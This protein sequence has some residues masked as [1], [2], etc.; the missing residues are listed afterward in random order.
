[1]TS[2]VNWMWENTPVNWAIIWIKASLTCGN[3]N[4]S[5]R[6]R[7]P[8]HS[9]Q[10]PTTKKNL[11]RCKTG[12]HKEYFASHIVSR[13][14]CARSRCR[15][16]QSMHMCACAHACALFTLQY[17]NGN[18]Q[19]INSLVLDKN[20]SCGSR[21][22]ASLL[23]GDPWLWGPD[24]GSH[25]PI[26]P[27]PEW[28]RQDAPDQVVHAVRWWWEAAVNRGGACP[29]H[30]QGCQVHIY[31]RYAGLY[32]R[33]CVDVNDN[34]L[35]YLEAIHNF[36]VVLNESFHN[37]CKLDLVFNFYKVYATDVPGRRNP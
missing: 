28:G 27:H 14:Q 30:C 19:D 24:R 7:R 29:G 3:V 35:A 9:H 8:P 26:H 1:M 31:W 18:M 20:I 32:F 34:N 6:H 23:Q 12:E 10:Q 21:A 13:G 5:R 11:G 36:I 25:D 17:V 37:V 15:L 2:N 22:E 33:I 4:S 16:F